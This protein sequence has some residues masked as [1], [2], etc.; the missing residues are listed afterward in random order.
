[1]DIEFCIRAIGLNHL[2]Q[3]PLTYLLANRLGFRRDF[4]ELPPLSLRVAENMGV[5]AVL[6]PTSLGLALAAH[7]GEVLTPGAARSLAFGL[8]IFWT[9]RLVRQVTAIGPLMPPSSRAFHIVLL[10]IFVLQGPILGVLV[11]AGR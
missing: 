10:S 5:A 8:S 9:W 4:G 3:P 1:M 11:F 7:A 6:L 2:L